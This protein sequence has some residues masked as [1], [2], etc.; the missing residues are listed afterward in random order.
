MGVDLMSTRSGILFVHPTEELLMETTIPRVVSIYRSAL[1][2][3][4]PLPLNDSM[5]M[6][7]T[8]LVQ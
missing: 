4:L 7:R 2:A 3:L 1:M 5:E 8:F 6:T